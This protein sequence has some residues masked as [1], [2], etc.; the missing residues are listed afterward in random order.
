M[1]LRA[2]AMGSIL[3]ILGIALISARRFSWAYLAISIVGI[4]VLVAGLVWNPAPA[5]PAST[6]A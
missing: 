6:G 4:A 5:K 2:L 1:K 3:T